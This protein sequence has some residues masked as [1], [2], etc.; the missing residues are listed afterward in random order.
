MPIFCRRTTRVVPRSIW[1]PIFRFSVGIVYRHTMQPLHLNPRSTFR[2]SPQ[3]LTANFYTRLSQFWWWPR[4]KEI[5]KFFVSLSSSHLL[6]P[7]SPLRHSDTPLPICKHEQGTRTL[8]WYREESQRWSFY[9]HMFWNIWCS[10][11]IWLWNPSF[12]IWL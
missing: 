6:P 4:K 2:L 3:P 5:R 1:S 12:L 9:S 10:Y 8:R 7:I 11:L